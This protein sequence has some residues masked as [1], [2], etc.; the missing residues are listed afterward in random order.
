M[1]KQYEINYKNLTKD[2]IFEMINATEKNLKGKIIFCND[3][4]EDIRINKEDN[5]NKTI[6]NNNVFMNLNN[7]QKINKEIKQKIIKENNINK[8]LKKIIIILK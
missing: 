5:Y 4:N 6:I 1:I 3:I 8:Q 7:Y 2:T